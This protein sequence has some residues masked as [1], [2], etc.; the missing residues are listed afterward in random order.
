MTYELEIENFTGP[1]DLL[2]QL[3]KEQEIEIN[4]ISLARVTDQYLAYLRQLEEFDLDSASEFTQI[5]A[6]LLEIKV[7]SLL[8]G[9][10]EENEQEEEESQLVARLRE[11]KLIK[12]LCE[13]MSRYRAEAAREFYSRYLGTEPENKSELEVKA[14]SQTLF[15]LLDQ[16]LENYHKRREKQQKRENII[17]LARES[18]SV[19]E[20]SS[21][22][23]NLIYKHSSRDKFLFE[24]FIS[25]PA[26]RIEVAA[27][28]L[29]LLEL[30]LQKAV[31][32]EQEQ[33]FG[34]IA[35]IPARSE[36]DNHE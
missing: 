24:E 4:E 27:T 28:L 29:S 13:E 23:L 8:P 30:S 26:D 17:N 33:K 9:D 20:K 14:D 22:I 12:E 32:L 19:Q 25:S 36:G 18:I 7:R 5:G 3:V 1:I 34:E 10:K 15:E 35:I 11:H 31:R 21:E 16:V 2:Y 6:E